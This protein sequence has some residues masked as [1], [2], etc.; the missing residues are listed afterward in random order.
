MPSPACSLLSA[1]CKGNCLHEYYVYSRVKCCHCSL[2][3]PPPISSRV[4]SRHALFHLAR[5]ASLAYLASTTPSTKVTR[6]HHSI[7]RTYDHDGV[8]NP[9]LGNHFIRTTLD[10]LATSLF[11]LREFTNVFRGSRSRSKLA[12]SLHKVGLKPL[13]LCWYTTH[14]ASKD[15]E[16]RS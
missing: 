4:H 13:R 3:R 16:D 1:L 9:L 8:R 15:K 2:P 7:L 5:N 6:K 14:R 11:A 12:Q 10:Y